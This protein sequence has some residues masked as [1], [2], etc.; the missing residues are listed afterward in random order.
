MTIYYYIIYILLPCSTLHTSPWLIYFITRRLYLL[1]PFDHFSQ[2]PNLPPLWQP[3]IYSLSLWI[4][5]CL[6]V[7]LFCFS[8]ATCDWNHMA[9]VLLWFISLSTLK[10]H[11]CCH[12]WHNFIL[13]YGWVLLH[14]VC[15]YATFFFIDEHLGCSYILAIVNDAAM[16]IG[17]CMS[18]QISG[19][20]EILEWRWC[21]WKCFTFPE[22]GFSSKA[23]FS[24]LCVIFRIKTFQWNEG[25]IG[26]LELPVTL[27]LE[28]A[29]RTM[30]LVGDLKG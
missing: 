23:G 8:D 30:F 5:C 15:I 4:L 12:K 26:R 24:F 22:T 1:I 20:S 14:C 6:F 13:F 17:V 10:I 16:N 27:N 2:L 7:H 29:H 18:F 3:P 11:P 25:K 9:F 19:G 28:P 21:I